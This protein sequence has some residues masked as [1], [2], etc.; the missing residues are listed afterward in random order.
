MDQS[1]SSQHRFWSLLSKKLSGETGSAEL[2]ELQMML[3]SNPDLHHH[4]DMLTE[5][6]EQ[7]KKNSN[8]ASEAAYM[9]H[10]MKHKDEFFDEEVQEKIVNAYPFPEERNSF[11]SKKRTTVFLFAL[12]IMIATGAIYLF[13]G[14][15]NVE[16]VAPPSIS[17]VTTKNGNR[18]KIVLPD[19]S[20]VWLNAGS[21]LHYDNEDFNKN[22]RE[23]SLNGEAYFDVVK[24]PEKPFIIHTNKM[25]IKV[26][27]TAFNV[28]SYNNEKTAEASLIR[29]TIEVTLKDRKDQKIVLNPNE[30]ISV[31]N[32][33]QVEIAVKTG[34]KI[35]V[36]QNAGTIPPIHIDNLKPNPVIN[37]IPEIAWTDNR[38]FFEDESLEDLAP[39]LERWFGKTVIVQNESLKKNRYRGNFKN[40]TIESVLSY[41]KF[42]K[43]FN[44]K[45]ENDTVVIY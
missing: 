40:E 26:I 39:L 15:D 1:N 19:G 36:K 6:W 5:M 17:S 34:E 35:A 4:A 27:G 3:L 21:N 10:S 32:E 9:R 12:F 14:K 28:R 11:F 22:I 2:Q 25:D 24:N 23:V 38:L 20:Q 18:S 8:T 42:S 45:F 13:M 41:L 31:A 7:Q 16:T 44:F 30:K 37:I 33:E 43:T 29:G